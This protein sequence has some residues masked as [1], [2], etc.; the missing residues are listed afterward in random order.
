MCTPEKDS[1]SI[2][3]PW[4]RRTKPCRAI[5]VWTT[6]LALAVGLAPD[7]PAAA[8]LSDAAGTYQLSAGS[9]SQSGGA[10]GG[11]YASLDTGTV[12][13]GTNGSSQAVASAAF[14][15]GVEPQVD[16]QAAVDVFP[17]AHC[18]T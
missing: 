5:A 11:A 18:P 14:S 10:Q 16:A 7:T 6:A 2:E 12:D 8:I 9:L 13:Y 15:F 3:N 1:S 4:V 17:P